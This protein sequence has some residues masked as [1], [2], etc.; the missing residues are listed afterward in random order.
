MSAPGGFDAGASL[1]PDNP[2][3]Q[4]ATL[5]GGGE[6]AEDLQKETANAVSMLAITDEE[7]KKKFAQEYPQCRKDSNLLLTDGCSTVRKYLA[8]KMF[9]V[10]V[11]RTATAP[12]KIDAARAKDYRGDCKEGILTFQYH[13][14]KKLMFTDYQ[15][16]DEFYRIYGPDPVSIYLKFQEAN[17][18]GLKSGMNVVDTSGSPPPVVAA[19]PPKNT[20]KVAAVETAAK[21]N[22]GSLNK[23][24][25]SQLIPVGSAAKENEGSLNAQS[26]S[27]LIPVE[28]ET[29]QYKTDVQKRVNEVLAAKKAA[30]AAPAATAAE[31]PEQK[32]KPS[33]GKQRAKRVLAEKQVAAA[34]QAA[35]PT[36]PTPPATGG[37]KRTR[38]KIRN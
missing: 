33:A 15:K 28:A 16:E 24:S 12:E 3:A 25:T 8:M 37:N 27:E 14:E 5:R 2:S 35:P 10:L 17:P 20:V 31:Q 13:I 29:G 38:R 9:N 23:D 22:E 6:G 32:P 21:E 7:E 11:E 36:Q 26:K 4:I 19:E 1:L 18:G 34:E 30:A